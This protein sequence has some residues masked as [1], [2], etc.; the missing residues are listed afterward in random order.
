MG[1][2]SEAVA[3]ANLHHDA[4]PCP[5]KWQWDANPAQVLCHNDDLIRHAPKGAS[6]EEAFDVMNDRAWELLF[7][8]SAGYQMHVTS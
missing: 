3:L 7:G 5:V 2:Y 1:L 8:G 4:G 6:M